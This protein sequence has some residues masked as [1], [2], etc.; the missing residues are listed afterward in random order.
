M[1]T[2]GE[3][4]VSAA[5]SD[6]S[7]EVEGSVPEVSCDR[8]RELFEELQKRKKEQTIYTALKKK[9]SLTDSLIKKYNS[10]CQEFDQQQKKLQDVTIKLA[11]SKGDCKVL[12]EQLTVTLKE[13]VPWKCDKNKFLKEYE[14]CKR[15]LSE[16]ED[17]LNGSEALCVQFESR[18]EEMEIELDTVVKQKKTA[19]KCKQM[20]KK[21]SAYKEDLAKCRK[22]LTATKNRES[23]LVTI[24]QKAKNKI[25]ELVQILRDAGFSI[26][27]IPKSLLGGNA[28]RHEGT[29][30]EETDFETVD[31]VFSQPQNTSS[32]PQKQDSPPE[33]AEHTEERRRPPLQEDACH[34]IFERF[35]T[36]E[37]VN[38]MSPLPPSPQPSLQ[39][40]VLSDL[41]SNM[42]EDDTR[43]DDAFS[44]V[45]DE[46]NNLM[47]VNCQREE[48][49]EG[50]EKTQDEGR[51]RAVEE[52]QQ[53]TLERS[54]LLSQVY[55]DLCEDSEGETTDKPNP[56]EI[57]QT[58]PNTTPK[59][60]SL[61]EAKLESEE[62]LTDDEEEELRDRNSTSSQNA[63][64]C[65]LEGV[66]C[67]TQKKHSERELT[68]VDKSRS[69]TSSNVSGKASEKR[70]Q[71]DEVFTMGSSLSDESDDEDGKASPGKKPLENPEQESLS[72]GS[73][74][75]SPVIQGKLLSPIKNDHDKLGDASLKAQKKLLLS[76]DQRMTRSQLKML[77]SL[78]NVELTVSSDSTLVSD[79]TREKSHLDKISSPAQ[80]ES[81]V[82]P[83]RT[84][85][86]SDE[87]KLSAHDPE[88]LQTSS[89]LSKSHPQQ[90]CRRP[91]TRSLSHSETES[92][93]ETAPPSPAKSRKKRALRFNSISDP[94]LS[95]QTPL[96]K[97]DVI[98]AENELSTCLDASSLNRHSPRQLLRSVS[99]TDDASVNK[100]VTNEI[101]EEDSL[102][103]KV[104]PRVSQKIS[105]KTFLRSSSVPGDT[106]S[107]KQAE[108]MPRRI[109]RSQK[110]HL[111]S[112]PRK[113]IVLKRLTRSSVR[114]SAFK[115]KSES[116]EILS[117]KDNLRLRRN[118]ETVS[119][120]ESKVAKSLFGKQENVTADDCTLLKSDNTL[121]DVG[122]K[123]DNS[124]G[125]SVQAPSQRR[126]R[127]ASDAVNSDD[128][129]TE[130][131]EEPCGSQQIDRQG[132]SLKNETTLK[133]AETEVNQVESGAKPETIDGL[134]LPEGSTL[135]ASHKIQELC[136]SGDESLL[137]SLS[138]QILQDNSHMHQPSQAKSSL[139]RIDPLE[140]DV[141]NKVVHAEASSYDSDLPLGDVSITKKSPQGEGSYLEDLKPRTDGDHK[142]SIEERSPTCSEETNTRSLTPELKPSSSKRTILDVEERILK[143][144]KLSFHTTENDKQDSKC[145]G[146][147][148][149][150]STS[151]VDALT[152]N[153]LNVE[154]EGNEE[155]AVPDGSELN[156]NRCQVSEDYPEDEQVQQSIG[157]EAETGLSEEA[158][159]TETNKRRTSIEL[160]PN[161]SREE[162]TLE[163]VDSADA[164]SEHNL[165]GGNAALTEEES[166]GKDEMME[167][168]ETN[169][170]GCQG[171]SDL[172][173]VFTT[174]EGATASVEPSLAVSEQTSSCG[175]KSN[176]ITGGEDA[177]LDDKQQQTADKNEIKGSRSGIVEGSVNKEGE[178]D[179]SFDEVEQD[180]AHQAPEDSRDTS[181]KAS[182]I[183]SLLPRAVCQLER[184]L[185][186]SSSSTQE[187]IPCNSNASQVVCVEAESSRASTPTTDILS[188]NSMSGHISPVSPLSFQESDRTSPL[189]PLASAPQSPLVSPLS[190]SP[191]IFDSLVA[192][193]R[194]LSPLPPSPGSPE[195]D[196]DEDT[197]EQSAPRGV[198]SVDVV[199]R[200]RMISPLF[201]TPVPPVV[202]PLLEPPIPHVLSPLS[203]TSPQRLSDFA[204]RDRSP[205]ISPLRNPLIPSPCNFHAEAPR[206]ALSVRPQHLPTP[207]RQPA[208]R[209]LAAS[210]TI[211]TSPPGMSLAPEIISPRLHSLA[212]ELVFEFGESQPSTSGFQR[213]RL[214][215]IAPSVTYDEAGTN[216]SDK[217]GNEE[218][219]KEDEEQI[220]TSVK[221]GF[222]K[223]HAKPSAKNEAA[224]EKMPETSIKVD[225]SGQNEPESHNVPE[226]KREKSS[227]TSLKTLKTPKRT[228]TNNDDP[229]KTRRR[230]KQNSADEVVDDKSVGKF[231]RRKKAKH[232]S[233]SNNLVQSQTSE[234]SE[235]NKSKRCTR[236]RSCVPTDPNLSGSSLSTPSSL[237]QRKSDVEKN[238]ET[239]LKS[240]KRRKNSRNRSGESQ[241][242]ERSIDPGVDGCSDPSFMETSRD[243]A[244]TQH[245]SLN[246]PV[247][248]STMSERR[249]ALLIQACE[250]KKVSGFKKSGSLRKT[251][252]SM[253]EPE[254]LAR[255][256]DSDH[257]TNADSEKAKATQENQG[258]GEGKPHSREPKAVEKN[259]L[260]ENFRIE[261]N[262]CEN[263]S[264]YR[265]QPQE[266]VAPAPGDNTNSYKDLAEEQCNSNKRTNQTPRPTGGSLQIPT[267]FTT[268]SRID[269]QDQQATLPKAI[270][271]KSNIGSVW[272]NI[273][274]RKDPRH[275]L[276]NRGKKNKVRDPKT[277]H[278]DQSLTLRGTVKTDPEGNPNPRLTDH[279]EAMRGKSQF[280][281]DNSDAFSSDAASIFSPRNPPPHQRMEKQTAQR[282]W[283]SKPTKTNLSDCKIDKT[284][285]SDTG[286]F[287][288]STNPTKTLLPS[289]AED[290]R[291]GS[292]K[293]KVD[294]VEDLHSASVRAAASKKSGS[295]SLIHGRQTGPGGVKEWTAGESPMQTSHIPDP[296]RSKGD[297]KGR[298][299]PVVGN[300]GQ[301]IKEQPS[302][303]MAKIMTPGQPLTLSRSG[304]TQPVSDV[305]ALIHHI[306]ELKSDSDV[307]PVIAE[308]VNFLGSSAISLMPS[309][310]AKCWTKNT[311]SKAMLLPH[312][313][314]LVTGIMESV[315]ATTKS[316]MSQL[317]MCLSR[318]VQQAVPTESNPRVV[319]GAACCRMIAALARQIG[320]INRIRVLC[321]DLVR[322]EI[323][324]AAELLLNVAVTWTTVLKRKV[325]ARALPLCDAL[326]MIV[327]QR[328]ANAA[329]AKDQHA[330][331]MMDCFQSICGWNVP[332]E[333]A[334]VESCCQV[335]VSLQDVTITKFYL[336]VIS[337][338]RVA[339][340]T[341]KSYEL[342]KTVEV[343]AQ[344]LGWEWTND[345][346]IRE[347]L[348]PVLKIWSQGLLQATS[349]AGTG[350][351][352]LKPDG[353]GIGVETPADASACA[354]MKIIGNVASLGL[355]RNRQSV[356]EIL[357]MLAGVLQQPTESVPLTVQFCTADA[358]L[359]LSP[360][361][362]T[363]A[364]AVLQLWKKKQLALLPSRIKDKMAVLTK[365]A[366]AASGV[367]N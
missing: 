341:S 354:V 143:K 227:V 274:S 110:Q 277:G 330:Q 140:S 13:I 280:Q 124:W 102:L 188:I 163:E 39:D 2:N 50:G 201:P 94:D 204:L 121:G 349:P 228:E 65:D 239:T 315:F 152:E 365:V 27:R 169:Q 224:V 266:D 321:F 171:N 334:I 40:E 291:S 360:S 306:K 158:Q 119:T 46:I 362:P 348:W 352:R 167:G 324:D 137:D 53:A 363:F 215:N 112:P 217:V 209:C 185:L 270:Q 196:L 273:A 144:P 218:K 17:K 299:R 263:G 286:T 153:T 142:G 248:P 276:F 238:S 177:D 193:P 333:N 258:T 325:G 208:S 316:H 113:E 11:S 178:S 252:D 164:R 307:T 29:S 287:T 107:G 225:L 12:E 366:C 61:I 120:K 84:E 82:L 45:A 256:R 151:E 75:I 1:T 8:C 101:P 216:T 336:S 168:V 150:E 312:E 78:G 89:E 337:E 21:A 285:T 203:D 259:P 134:K 159:V 88:K 48:S 328:L 30:N 59:K 108:D 135:K 103:S 356:Y 14:D 43:D 229:P 289:V 206:D 344:H 58:K 125:E 33:E 85:S 7:G 272:G 212:S 288:Q 6:I 343:Y 98:K 327:M 322:E 63:K 346:L 69:D 93:S 74:K 96:M 36:S 281:L 115:T 264:I 104:H 189:S 198:V 38:C 250:I 22:E 141:R 128:K 220:P 303:K 9:I 147:M 241:V 192:L 31:E 145:F 345:F 92:C 83:D 37:M 109:T 91:V 353:T 282:P 127:A 60:E 42:S 300:S 54:K 18:L 293:Q 237:L 34:K 199:N 187:G 314:E 149:S 302:A 156:Q 231:S 180:V 190:P 41:S 210:F 255:A 154:G 172:E 223:I 3:E 326:E 111:G 260:S 71:D 357:K 184:F 233:E 265:N 195:L 342:V 358:V 77:A 131:Q 179:I 16:T 146:T 243:F 175:T 213:Q 279:Q 247:G 297:I 49:Q 73:L 214:S 271:V 310:R 295:S 166:E 318:K 20:E 249:Q 19:E 305:E 332:I 309:I 211:A 181:D 35:S 351:D 319:V 323:P 26:P 340:L 219:S 81:S 194:I 24:N 275:D 47:E 87:I 130:I 122:P 183:T 197:V 160:S 182:S 105:P 133:V 230:I 317:M 313:Q 161:A 338:P 200:P 76:P 174:E 261:K 290:L 28:D 99:L 165:Q 232:S 222:K 25:S 95:C 304:F 173:A 68:D 70:N 23:S 364:L 294:S 284:K 244:S 157:E 292:D 254:A 162:L 335:L 339:S 253:H 106:L 80:R 236:S 234:D 116:P 176:S 301:Y 235:N 55:D 367:T 10:K 139:E 267:T 359:S 15:R 296:A 100:T 97:S 268:M 4:D 126:T 329:A 186:D 298:K 132:E 242:N 202:S 123:S 347:K 114:K 283:S 221:R 207:R 246:Q 62:L 355:K 245:G 66:E 117:K 191:N 79:H 44:D 308:V 138:K 278:G 57:V 257:L 148:T 86:K 136:K 155:E 262:L 320:A 361:N 311:S 32:S 240:S 226:Q 205:M 170:I 251:K 118:S 56:D 90:P 5:N 129:S 67:A 64:D 331:Q 51:S 52:P 72:A 269:S 350:P